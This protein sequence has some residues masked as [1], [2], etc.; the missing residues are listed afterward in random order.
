VIQTKSIYDGLEATDGIRIL[1]ARYWPRHYQSSHFDKYYRCLAPSVGLLCKWKQHQITWSQYTR[2]Y[3]QEMKK[4]HA[5]RVI[6]EVAE[7][8][9]TKTVTLLCYEAESNPCCH[10][11][12]LKVL[13]E[14]L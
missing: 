7:L 5:H 10:R 6:K 8:S 1:I 4:P 9:K 14:N 12:I 3:K 2:L 11:H 13:I